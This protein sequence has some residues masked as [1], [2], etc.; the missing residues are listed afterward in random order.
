MSAVPKPVRETT[1]YHDKAVE[2]A[3]KISTFDGGC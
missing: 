3:G 2:A 1:D